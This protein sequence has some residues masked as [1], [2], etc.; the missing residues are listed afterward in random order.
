VLWKTRIATKIV[1]EELC[2]VL[3]PKMRSQ[4]RERITNDLIYVRITQKCPDGTKNTSEHPLAHALFPKGELKSY[5]QNMASGTT[6]VQIEPEPIVKL[7][8]DQM[9][10]TLSEFQFDSLWNEC[11]TRAEK[12]RTYIRM[13]EETHLLLKT[14]REI[15]DSMATI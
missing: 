11:I 12:D 9:G 15:L 3:P 6:E 10:F 8:P 13:N 1:N 5:F 2:K 14:G 7:P 4:I